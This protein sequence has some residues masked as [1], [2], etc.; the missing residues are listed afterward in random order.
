MQNIVLETAEAESLQKEIEQHLDLCYLTI[1]CEHDDMTEDEII[2]LDGFQ[3]FDV[4]C[5]CPTCVSRE[6]IMKTFEHLTYLSKVNI[7][8]KKDENEK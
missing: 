2:L 7:T 4:F 5:G 3:P 8:V 6:I 1:E